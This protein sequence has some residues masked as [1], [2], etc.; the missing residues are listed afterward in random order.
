MK[1]IVIIGEL[2]FEKL[3]AKYFDKN[4]INPYINII[5]NRSKKIG[6]WLKDN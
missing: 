3:M 1:D 4:E 6:G 2:R 5:K